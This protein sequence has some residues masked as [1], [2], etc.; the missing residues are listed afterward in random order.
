MPQSSERQ[1]GWYWV[2][3]PLYGGTGAEPGNEL[4][5]Y[6]TPCRLSGGSW[7][8]AHSRGYAPAEIG[9]RIPAPNEEVDK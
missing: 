8:M 5:Q 3:Y 7:M 9:P 4:D 1:D 2:R 6:W